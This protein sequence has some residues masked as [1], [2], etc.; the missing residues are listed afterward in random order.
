MNRTERLQRNLASYRRRADRRHALGLTTL[1]K[2]FK[3]HPNMP[4]EGRVIYYRQTRRT[5]YHV[6]AQLN[7]RIGL[8]ARGTPRKRRPNYNFLPRN[9]KHFGY[10]GLVRREAVS[11]YHRRAA[12][13]HAQGLTYNGRP[14]RR[15]LARVPSMLTLD[16]RKL[17]AG[18]TLPRFSLETTIFERSE[19]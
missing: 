4:T 13:F 19:S 14:Y 10:V 2:P 16:W 15:P 3:R 17:R 18:V 1:G 12:K 9:V 7:F 8:T 6:E 11:R 5:R